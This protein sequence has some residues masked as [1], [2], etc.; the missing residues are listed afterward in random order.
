MTRAYFPGM[1]SNKHVPKRSDDDTRVTFQLPKSLLA[2]IDAAAKS[3]FQN[4]SQFLV[5]HMT[6]VTGGQIKA[7]D[8]YENS[9]VAE[10]QGKS[11]PSTPASS[12][13][14]K[15]PTGRIRKKNG[16]K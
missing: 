6:Q 4:R 1:A 10:E 9:K 16:T 13:S 3:S 12:V 11:S 7:L 14:I 15:Y 8:D 2:K 5:K